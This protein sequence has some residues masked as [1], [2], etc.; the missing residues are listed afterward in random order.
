[1][2]LC[3]SCVPNIE[4][5]QTLHIGAETIQIVYLIVSKMKGH[6]TLQ[7]PQTRKTLDVVLGLK[8]TAR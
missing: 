7:L 6:E 1:M 4:V 2:N 8:Q 5:L 3:N